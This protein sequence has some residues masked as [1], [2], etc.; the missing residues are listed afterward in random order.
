MLILLAHRVRRRF[1]TIDYLASFAIEVSCPIDRRSPA[2]EPTAPL[3]G[4]EQAVERPCAGIASRSYR[5]GDRSAG[6]ALTDARGPEIG[7]EAIKK[8][9]AVHHTL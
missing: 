6:H 7:E 2:L 8:S 3:A 5:C 1:E 4:V 9:T